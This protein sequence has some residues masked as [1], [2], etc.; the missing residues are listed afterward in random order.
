MPRT[1]QSTNIH[2][3]LLILP[4]LS[5]SPPCLALRGR[6]IAGDCHSGFLD[7]QHLGGLKC[8]RTVQHP[9]RNRE[10]HAGSQFHRVTTFE[11][12]T[13]ATVD[14]VEELV[15]L[16]VLVPVVLA[17]REH[18]QAQQDTADLYQSLVVPG[19]VRPRDRLTNVDELKRTEQRLIIDLVVSWFRHMPTLLAWPDAPAD[20]GHA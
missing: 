15:L 5:Q 13:Q 4:A 8:H 6:S 16:L 7:H 2:G 14:D 3:V 20:A 17:T 1:S 19:V 18:A 9:A 10:C 12:D 11:F